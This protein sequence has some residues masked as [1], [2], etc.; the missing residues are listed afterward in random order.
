MNENYQG[1]S[2]SKWDCKDHV[3]FVPKRRRKELF[4]DIRKQLRSDLSRTGASEGL[5]DHRR[6]HDARPRPNVHCDSSHTRSGI[7]DW[8]YQR[9][10][11]NCDC[12]IARER[13]QLHRKTFLGTRLRVLNRWLQ[14]RANQALHPRSGWL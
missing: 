4:G 1:L 14:R 10:K 13:T 9:Q 3:V 2:H 5:P 8:V 11:C 12:P 7:S 6:P